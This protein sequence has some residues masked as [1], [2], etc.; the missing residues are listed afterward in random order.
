MDHPPFEKEYLI[1][2]EISGDQQLRKSL[3]GDGRHRLIETNNSLNMVWQFF[4]TN[5]VLFGDFLFSYSRMPYRP[6]LRDRNGQD[7]PINEHISEGRSAFSKEAIKAIFQQQSF[8]D[9]YL[10]L[11]PILISQL[12]LMLLDELKRDNENLIRMVRQYDEHRRRC[13]IFANETTKQRLLDI[14]E[15][16]SEK[17]E[18]PRWKPKTIIPLGAYP[19]SRWTFQPLQKF[20]IFPDRYELGF[21]L[22][23]GLVDELR[24]L[25]SAGRKR[26][27]QLESKLRGLT[28]EGEIARLST[29]AAAGVMF[30]ADSASESKWVLRDEQ[31]DIRGRIES[32]IG[33]WVR[34]LF[35]TPTPTAVDNETGAEYLFNTAQDMVEG[36]QLTRKVYDLMFSPTNF[37][38]PEFISARPEMG[39]AT[40]APELPRENGITAPPFERVDEDLLVVEVIEVVQPIQE[41]WGD[42]PEVEPVVV[43]VQGPVVQGPEVPVPSAWNTVLPGGTGPRERTPRELQFERLFARWTEKVLGPI[44]TWDTF[45]T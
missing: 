23:G 21:R 15:V 2:W 27:E 3:G 28:G 8:Y 16:L 24:D 26:R 17:N 34:L 9:V 5:P 36:T 22:L 39:V 13:G 1:G 7:L 20:T 19:V 45:P 44:N 29:A 35:N 41:G 38:M 18:G 31:R 37:Y 42:E 25:E 12:E 32:F 10:G 33:F 11:L 4:K 6:M 40:K 30:F 14:K 43:V